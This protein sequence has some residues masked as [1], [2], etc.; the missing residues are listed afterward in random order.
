MEKELRVLALFMARMEERHAREPQLWAEMKLK[1][2]VWAHEHT[3]KIHTLKQS[4]DELRAKIDMGTE[5]ICTLLHSHRGK[6][7]K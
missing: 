2:E 6:F 7:E 1:Y 5:R 3:F 4:L